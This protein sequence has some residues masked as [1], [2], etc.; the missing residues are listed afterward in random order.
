MYGDCRQRALDM[1][2]YGFHIVVESLGQYW[3]DSRVKRALKD[4][5]ERHPNMR[6]EE[7]NV[8]P[9]SPLRIFVSIRNQKA[10]PRRDTVEKYC[11]SAAIRHGILPTNLV[12]IEDHTSASTTEKVHEE[13]HK[14]QGMLQFF[15]GS[16]ENPLMDWLNA[17]FFLASDLKIPRIRIMD[18]ALKAKAT[19]ERDRSDLSFSPDSSDQQVKEVIHRAFEK[20]VK[21]MRTHDR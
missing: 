20:L 4:A 11:K 12:L 6:L 8:A 10:F 3:A 9:I 16:P 1:E 13:I 7:A 2:E 14:C 5:V 15:M 19:F 21:E 17:E 18:E